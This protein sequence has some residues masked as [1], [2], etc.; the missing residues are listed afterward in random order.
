M[1]INN[2]AKPFEV[3]RYPKREELPAKVVALF[4]A[5]LEDLNDSKGKPFG[6]KWKNCGHYKQLGE[7]FYHCHLTPSYVVVWKIVEEDGVTICK[8]VYAGT[9]EKVPT[10]S[11]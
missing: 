10:R 5:L 8:V 11:K 6:R 2:A 9:R 3:K 1:S 4:E 7:N